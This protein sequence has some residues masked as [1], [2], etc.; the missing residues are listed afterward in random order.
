MLQPEAPH[1]S[2]RGRVWAQVEIEDFQY[3]VRPECQGG[4]WALAQ[5]MK[6]LRLIS[7]LKTA[8]ARQMTL[9]SF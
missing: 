6:V 2:G 9:N 8:G 4:R 5:R 7:E 3:F 1:L